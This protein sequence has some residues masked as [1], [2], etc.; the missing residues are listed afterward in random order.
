[1]RRLRT[2][3]LGLAAAWLWLLPAAVLG[4]TP[5]AA[6]WLDESLPLQ[7]PADRAIEGQHLDLDVAIDLEAGAVRGTAIWQ[8][9]VKHPTSELVLRAAELT[10]DA[11]EWLKDGAASPATFRKDGDRLRFQLPP[12]EPPAPWT[13]KLRYHATPRRGL[14]FVRPDADTPRRPLHAFTQGET[15]EARYW[16]PCLDDPDARQTW[17]VTLTAPAALRALSN[18]REVGRKVAGSLASTTYEMARP[19]PIYL[20][21]AVIGPFVEIAHPHQGI[22]LTTYTLPA[23]RDDAARAFA[24]LPAM[25][26]FYEKLLGVPFPFV[27]YGQVAVDEFAFGGMENAGLTTLALRAIPDARAE[28]DG[29]ADGLLAHELA[30]QWFGDLVTCRSWSD[31]WLNEGFATYFQMLF[32]EHQQGAD[33]LDEEL[34]DARK[35]YFAEAAE[36]ERPLV[37]ERYAEADDLF[38]RHAYQKGA[39]VLHMLRRSLGD[40][41]FFRGI[42]HYLETHGSGSVETADLRRALEAVSGRSLRGFFRRWLLQPGHPQVTANIRHENQMLRITFEQKQRVTPQQPLFDLPIALAVR[43]KAEDAPQ[44]ATFRLDA[45]RGEWTWPCAAMPAVIEIDPAAALLAEWTVQADAGVLAAMRDHGSTADVR[46]RAVRDVARDQQLQTSSDAL[47]RA[48]AQDPARHVRAEAATWLGR[49]QRQVTRGGLLKALQNDAEPMVRSAAAAALGELHDAEAWPELDKALRKD[50]SHGVQV[51]ALRALASIDRQRA[52]PVL[53]EAAGWPS[54]NHIV[55]VA[56][57]SA[58]GQLADARDVELLRKMVE[59]GH[60]KALR[61]GA[62]LGLAAYGVR[63]EPARE[64]IR[65]TLE[66]MLQEPS[67]RIRSGAAAALGQL[68]ETA[69]RPALLAAAAREIHGHAAQAM[70]RAVDALGKR[71][72]A[73]ERIKRLED[74]VSQLH[75]DAKPGER[76]DGGGDHSQGDHSHDD[77]GQHAPPRPQLSEPWP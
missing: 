63:S 31:V 21:S 44:R 46:L 74:A 15:A 32:E 35:S 38:D 22:A 65:L 45:A 3:V 71:L 25:V 73:E 30:H 12:R 49:G 47:L 18:G 6:A 64:G 66:A 51:A 42:R 2:V 16:L 33:R 48:L 4:R 53:V 5:P 55:E 59:P 13:L 70:R 57:L 8:G 7:E 14:Y 9:V 29:P 36:Y 61:E 23:Q 77:K 41:L 50:R 40:A 1:M 28:L 72:P 54:H 34:A 62:V 19:E 75:R 60:D 39:W 27:R 52:R 58:L 37:A 76:R 43:Q 68:G 10:I 56:A 26:D 67:L 24:R 17:T 69:S 20:L 11:A